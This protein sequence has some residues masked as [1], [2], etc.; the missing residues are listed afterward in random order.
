MILTRWF[1]AN[2]WFTTR[3]PN[4]KARWFFCNGI[5]YKI[6]NN[7]EKLENYRLDP[8]C[9][10]STKCSCDALTSVMDKKTQDQVKVFAW[11]KLSI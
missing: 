9:T 4:N 1:V 3:G 8:I 10:C 11:I 5:I 7:L 2:L 6:T